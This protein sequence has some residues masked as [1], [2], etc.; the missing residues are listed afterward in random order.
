MFS[1]ELQTLTNISLVTAIVVFYQFQRV[2]LTCLVC[3]KQRWSQAAAAYAYSKGE[4][5][6]LDNK[7]SEIA[8]NYE[9][10][11]RTGS[12]GRGHI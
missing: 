10:E 5:H 8:K 4:R 6:W 12:L 2:L 7:V 11:T 9:A 3:H 1:L